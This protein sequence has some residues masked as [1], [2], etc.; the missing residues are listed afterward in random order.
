MRGLPEGAALDED[1]QA[2][3][4]QDHGQQDVAPPAEGPGD[5]RAGG[6]EPACGAPDAD[7]D[8]EDH[9]AYDRAAGAD[10]GKDGYVD[11]DVVAAVGEGGGGD[12]GDRR[13]AWFE[14]GLLAA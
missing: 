5:D 4:D 9:A 6:D 14:S 3:G 13:A 7:Q 10:V 1:E 12:L 8:Q 11:A 2:D